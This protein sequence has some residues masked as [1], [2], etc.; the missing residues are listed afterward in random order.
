MK[1]DGEP[2]T[3]FE[4]FGHNE[5]CNVWDAKPNSVSL[6]RDKPCTCGERELTPEER[7]IAKQK[8]A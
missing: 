4:A 2:E 3:V 5:L 1:E 6:N 8:Y 7:E